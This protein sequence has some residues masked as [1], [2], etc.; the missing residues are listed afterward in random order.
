GW[1][2]RWFTDGRSERHPVENGVERIVVTG[3]DVW[4][5]TSD[6]GAHRYRNGVIQAFRH[7]TGQL[8]SNTVTSLT[9]VD[10]TTLIGT[11]RGLVRLDSHDNSTWITPAEGL[12]GVSVEAVFRRDSASAWIATNDKLHVWTASGIDPVGS[13]TTLRNEL[14]SAHWHAFDPE[15]NRWYMATPDGIVVVDLT[16]P[17]PLFPA[18]KVSIS[19]F[20]IQDSGYPA[21]MADEVTHT[22]ARTSLEFTFHGLTF[23]EEAATRYIVKLDGVD[24]AWSQPQRANT[25]RYANL[26]P[27][28]YTFRVKAVNAE[29]MPS[30]AE[31][32]LRL[33]LHPPLWMHPGAKVVAA[34]LLLMLLAAFTRWRIRSI[35]MEVERRNEQQQFEAI[36]RIGAS[37]SHDIRNTVFSLNLLAKNLEVRFNN[38]EFR[39]DA[40]ETIESSLNYLT[41]LVDQ[42]QQGST[43]P[44]VAARDVRIRDI[45]DSVLKRLPPSVV[46]VRYQIDWPAEA[47]VRS[48][49]DSLGRILD[50]LIRNATEAMAAGGTIRIHGEQDASGV[51]IFVTDQGPGMSADFMRNRLFRPF[52]STKTKGLGIGLYTCREL[53]IGL[54]GRL[55]V[56][57][58][59]GS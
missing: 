15:R 12:V 49:A 46:E 38:P 26:P 35:Q 31:A 47:V 32:T 21:W 27:G 56:E 17:A 11:K 10:G 28:T 18:P 37:L 58:V 25:V 3:E 48:D 30:D 4:W 9:T 53:A 16:T 22:G 59:P 39:K 8:P 52:Q 42:L 34:M 57:S 54:G 13:L 41:K 55:D 1:I 14:A 5:L 45:I 36:Q 19:G 20:R 44:Q 2:Y 40:I 29:N 6:D 24:E 23:I 7:D 43:V 50:N 33:T 51:R